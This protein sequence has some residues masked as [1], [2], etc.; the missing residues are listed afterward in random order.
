MITAKQILEEVSQVQSASSVPAKK[1]VI[2]KNPSKFKTSLPAR[3][4]VPDQ[5]EDSKDVINK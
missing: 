5:Q 1:K 4:P 2:D 3:K